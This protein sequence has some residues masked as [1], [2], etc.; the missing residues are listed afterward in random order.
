MEMLQYGAKL[1][2]QLSSPTRLLLSVAMENMVA[3]RSQAAS[4]FLGGGILDYLVS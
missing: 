2:S 4:I 1:A 3:L